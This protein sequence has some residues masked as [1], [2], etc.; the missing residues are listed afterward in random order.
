M[1]NARTANSIAKSALSQLLQMQP[2]NGVTANAADET[3][4]AVALW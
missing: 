2:R 3:R 1:Q 4:M